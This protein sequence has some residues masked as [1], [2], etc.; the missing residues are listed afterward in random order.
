MS[1]SN[2]EE[3]YPFPQLCFT[4]YGHFKYCSFTDALKVVVGCKVQ[5]RKGGVFV[6]CQIL[7]LLDTCII[8]LR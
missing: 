3:N 7:E 5:L 2:S 6:G 4:T 8:K 1:N